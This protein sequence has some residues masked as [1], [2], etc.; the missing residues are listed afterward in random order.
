V[1]DWPHL[2]VEYNGASRVQSSVVNEAHLDDVKSS[3]ASV[4][5]SPHEMSHGVQS[6]LPRGMPVFGGLEHDIGVVLDGLGNVV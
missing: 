1:E 3:T 6:E 2:S 5:G 4:S